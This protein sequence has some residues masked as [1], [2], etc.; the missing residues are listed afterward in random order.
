MVHVQPSA[1]LQRKPPISG[2]LVQGLKWEFAV[3]D[4]VDPNAFVVPG[5]T[6]VGTTSYLPTPAMSC[7]I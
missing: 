6:A 4:E 1:V 3:I 2:M 5:E 7:S